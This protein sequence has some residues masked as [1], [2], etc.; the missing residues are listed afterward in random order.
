MAEIFDWS[1]IDTTKCK[2][3]GENSIE[4]PICSKDRKKKGTKPL[5]VNITKGVAHCLHCAAS[6]YDKS[7]ESQRVDAFVKKNYKLPVTENLT[8]LSEGA[9]KWFNDKRGLMQKVLIDWNIQVSSQYFPQKSANDRCVAFPYYR[10]GK[11]VNVK[12]RTMDKSFRMEQGAELILYGLDN[13]KGSETAYICEGEIDAI[14]L[15]QCGFKSVVSVPNGVAI[16]EKEKELFK[17]T[18]EFDIDKPINLEYIDNSF[19]SI[20][21]ITKWILCTDGDLPGMKLR[22]E[23]LRRF[24]A[25]NCSLVSFGDC[26]DANEAMVKHGIQYVK[27]CVEN[28]KECE[29][30]GV[31]SS[32]DINEHLEFIFKNGIVKGHEIGIPEWDKHYRQKLGELDIIT[33][34]ANHGKSYF[35][36]W[37]CLLNSCMHGWKWYSC[38]RIILQVRF[39]KH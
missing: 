3:S 26:K 37:L 33:G 6:S 28:A 4:C 8:Q 15:S 17:N 11:V 16:S 21:H 18:G 7:K 23:L 32:K 5:R 22:F 2:S 10:D 12:Y 25:E 27:D 13:L 31:V 9:L 1:L 19:E 30:P 34:I 24:G 20:K 36:M 35:T 39:I 38:Q 14:T 29:I